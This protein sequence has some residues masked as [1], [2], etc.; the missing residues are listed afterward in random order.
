MGGWWRTG[1]E[2]GRSCVS[3]CYAWFKKT[4][5]KAANAFSSVL[6]SSVDFMAP[7]AVLSI[8]EDYLIEMDDPHDMQDRAPKM[9][10]VPL[11][12]SV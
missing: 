4:L 1:E 12:C 6:G 5:V 8:I 11:H 9:I 2:M 3:R 10:V 7:A